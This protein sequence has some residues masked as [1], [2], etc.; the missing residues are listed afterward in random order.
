MTTDRLYYRDSY[1]VDFSASVRRPRGRAARLP[2]RTAFYP[3]S[4]G[5]PHEYR[6]DCR[7]GDLER[8]D[9]GDRIAHPGRRS[10]SLGEAACRVDWPRR[11]DQCSSTAASISSPPC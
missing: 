6:H 7:R 10:H 11:F 1:L 2:R 3:D 8:V 4:G 5:Q 9:E